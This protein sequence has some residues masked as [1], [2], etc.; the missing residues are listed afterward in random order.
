MAKPL[1]VY[2]DNCVFNRPFDYQDKLSVELETEAKLY[3]QKHIKEK[4]ISLIWSYMLDYENQLNPFIER[5][6]TVSLW[7]K[8]AIVDIEESK[9]L[10]NQA[11]EILDLGIKSKDALHIASAITA[12]ADYFVTTDKEIL[13]KI[14]QVSNLTIINP[15]NFINILEDLK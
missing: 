3:I 9:K 12:E 1:K 15:V 10:I 8:Y 6:E 2:L 14:H 7:K 4:K 13:K 5:K 11:L